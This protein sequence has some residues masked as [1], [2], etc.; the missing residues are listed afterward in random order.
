MSPRS[1]LM[2][3]MRPYGGFSSGNPCGDAFA[4]TAP[5]LVVAVAPPGPAR[6][7]ASAPAFSPGPEMYRTPVIALPETYGRSENS[8]LGGG[9]SPRI[10]MAVNDGTYATW[11]SGS[12]EP[13]GQF[14]PPDD[15]KP[16]IG[17]SA[18]LTGGGVKMGPIL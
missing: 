6:T 14:V 13:P 10:G 2:A 7:G 3:V 11:D 5:S 9:S 17:P 4:F 8:L 12:N 18:L 16:A 15:R 1:R